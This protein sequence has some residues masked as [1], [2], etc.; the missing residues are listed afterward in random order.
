VNVIKFRVVGFVA[1]CLALAG[2]IGYIVYVICRVFIWLTRT[3]KVNK[4]IL[5]Y[6]KK[7]VDIVSKYPETKKRRQR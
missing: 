4:L 6:A 7:Y 3:K 2:Y 1:A 5:S